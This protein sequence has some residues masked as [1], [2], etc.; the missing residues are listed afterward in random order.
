MNVTDAIKNRISTRAFLDKTVPNDLI[1]II[2]DTARWAP[3]GTNIQPW[4]VAVVKGNAK[5]SLSSALINHWKNGG[6]SQPDYT[7]YPKQWVNPYK[8]RRFE[9][10][11]ALY[12]ALDIKREDTEKRKAVWEANYEF[13]GAPATLFFFIDKN[14]EKGSWFDMGMFIQNVMIC[15]EEHGLG[16]CPQASTADYPDLVREQLGIDDQYAVICGLALG[17]PDKSEAINQYRTTREAVEEF[18]S[19]HE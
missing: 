7:Y 15:A 14:M 3:S 2:L 9:C 4:K 13:F 6:A 10:G 8:K 18:T 16:T 1:E 12:S 5:D 11:M 19:W 17:Y